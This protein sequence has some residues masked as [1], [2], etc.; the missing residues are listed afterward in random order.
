[1][2]AGSGMESTGS[3]DGGGMLGFW[4]EL[5]DASRDC[6]DAVVSACRQ[7]G[8]RGWQSERW[9]LATAAVMDWAVVVGSRSRRCGGW[10]PPYVCLDLAGAAA[11]RLGGVATRR[12]HPTRVG[13]RGTSFEIRQGRRQPPDTG[14]TPPPRHSSPF[15]LRRRA[16]LTISSKRQARGGALHW[17]SRCS[18]AAAASPNPA[19]APPLSSPAS[20]HHRRSRGGS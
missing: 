11:S 2:A 1:M 20:L 12:G 14:E 9:S 3:A 15:V 18:S 17:W 4:R 5:T 13:L 10:H 6:R 7:C 19:S 8:V 16:E